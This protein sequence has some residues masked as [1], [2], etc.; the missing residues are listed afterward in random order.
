M[1]SSSLAGIILAAGKGTRM[2]SELPKGLH[3]VCGIPMV[4]HVARAMKAAGIERPIIV[5]GH[6]GELIQEA[7]GDGY[8]YAWQREQLGTGHAAKM[9]SPLLEGHSGPV[10]VAAGDTPL[11]QAEHFSE[12]IETHRESNA[13]ITL[14]TSILDNPK[15]YGR[16]VRGPGG[17]PIRI[18]EDKDANP[19]Q[20]L[21][22]EINV[23]LYCFDCPTLLRILPTLTNSNSQGEYYLTDVIDSV[24][25]EGGKLAAKVYDDPSVIVGVNDRWQMALAAKEMNRRI[26]QRHAV[27][28]VTLL[29]IDTISIGVDV[30][31]GVDTVIESGTILSG[32]T[33]IGKG[34]LIGPYSK[35]QNSS[36]GDG[37]SVIASYLD[38]AEVGD[39]VWIGPYAHLR[40]HAHLEDGAKVGNF[41]EIKNATVGKGAKVNHLSYVGDASVGAGANLGAGTITCNYD[42]HKKSKT[43][44]GEKTF[45]GSNSTLIA[46]VTIGDGAFV[47]AGSVITDDVP[48]DAGAFG[49]ARQET[50]PEW[51]AKRRGVLKSTG[52]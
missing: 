9:A 11:L 49:R 29:E 31:I 21:I 50:K 30:E 23:A 20:K 16:I 45:I 28:G 22:N 17:D 43:K 42:G 35:I 1:Q 8:D 46:P 33:S 52:H 5:I 48:N 25:S 12:L 19:D 24:Q 15:G 37:S 40:P 32:R 14:A 34:C 18:V 6:G 26:L 4:E 36:I 47:A 44:I 27:S 2:K 7:L 13:L 3:R 39:E 51:A 10:I 38:R 41:V